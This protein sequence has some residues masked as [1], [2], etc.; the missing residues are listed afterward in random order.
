MAT[1]ILITGGNRGDVE[2]VLRRAAEVVA[3]RVGTIVACSSLHSSRAWG[4]SSQAEFLN[5]VLVVSTE[6]E[7]QE[8]IVAVLE[9]ERQVGRD[10]AAEAEE[11]SL[12]G[13]RYASRVVDIDVLYYDQ[14]VIDTPAL[15]VPHPLL[16]QRE[17]V[18]RPLVEV[19]PEWV[20]PLLHKSS[21]ELLA[22]LE[23]QQAQ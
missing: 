3:E 8:L 20:H 13:Q 7:P 11:R 21:R 18:L 5:Q 14:Q 17:F 9:A 2:A 6:L 4:F 1:T 19:C 23:E 22:A 10:R 16:H 15:R 12:T